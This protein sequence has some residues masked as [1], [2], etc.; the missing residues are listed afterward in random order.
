MRLIL[1]GCEYS[2]TT[3]LAKAICRWA[4]REMGAFAGVPEAYK[5]HDHFKIP[6]I[7]HPPELNDDEQRQLLSLSPRLKETIQRHNIYYHLPT[8]SWPQDSIVIGLHIEDKI[9]GP[10]YFGYETEGDPRNPIMATRA[11]FERWIMYAAPDIVLVLVKA[12][13]EVILRRLKDNP[14]HNGV[15]QEEDVDYVLQRFE[16]EYEKSEIR[17][18]LTIDTTTATVEE[19]LDE[20]VRSIRKFLTETDRKRIAKRSTLQ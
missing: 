1:V 4:E 6:H 14:H 17:N 13:P 2:G 12:S 7:S 15:L 3:T 5:I 16:E 18:K 11:K 20:F 9:Y 19:S 10:L 8:Y